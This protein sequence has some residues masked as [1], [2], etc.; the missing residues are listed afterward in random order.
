MNENWSKILIY[1]GCKNTIA[2]EWSDAFYTYC[3][4]G[5]IDTPKRVAAFIANIMVESAFL[6]RLEENLNY[7]AQGLANTWPSRYSSTG[8]SGGKPNALANKLARNPQAIA[9][10]VYANR[11]GNG[12]EASG[13]GWKYR[14][15]GP[16]QLTGRNN[17]LQ[18]DTD[19]ASC[20][21][22]ESDRLMK[23]EDG[24]KSAVWF[25]N[26]N[27][28]SQY[29]DKKDFDGC[30]DKVNIGKKT[31]K[32]GDSH[33]YNNR[34]TIYDKLLNIL[35]NNT[36]LLSSVTKTTPVVITGDIT[37]DIIPDEINWDDQTD[38]LGEYTV[39]QG[40]FNFTR[41]KSYYSGY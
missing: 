10:N 34:K 3:N 4:E 33:G 39:K 5:G 17:R 32:V 21:I 35:E 13:D 11:M 8:K 1:S 6:T 9:N 16:I 27:N 40:I 12:N 25:W 24:V 41:V 15:M 37:L 20:T 23:P 29:A 31:T 28:I 30:C 36:D 14:G 2:D 7:S 26:L 19:C 18:Y 22:K 38:P